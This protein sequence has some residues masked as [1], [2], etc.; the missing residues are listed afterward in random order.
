MISNKFAKEYHN[1][2]TDNTSG[3]RELLIKL[4]KFLRNN[5]HQI[6]SDII[7]A[8][9]EN[10]SEFQSISTFLT[11]FRRAFN[12]NDSEQFL[13][14]Y[15]ADISIY[16]SILEK[17]KPHIESCNTF[18]T[19]SNS[20]TIL[21]VL[22]LIS[23]SNKRLK[24]IVSEGRPNNEGTLLAEKLTEINISTSLIT[25]AQIYNFVQQSDCALIGADKILANGN[26]INKVGSNLLA[27]ACKELNK[28]FLVLADQSKFSADN[29][30]LQKE[31]KREEIFQSVNKK[32]K[33]HNYYF[34]E[35]K[36]ELITK[37]IID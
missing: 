16:S 37:I 25:E 1:L 4:Y 20:K 13:N 7:A 12:N 15:V 9:Q 28:P 17:M 22:I 8:L 27:L 18:I 10:F 29:K 33:V 6:D 36:K 32:I 5:H 34:E 31:K 35:I 21:E 11:D 3:S 23:K 14:N 24:V 19:I 26:V 30:F 2:I